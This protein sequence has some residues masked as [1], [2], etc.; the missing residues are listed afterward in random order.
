MV[1]SYGTGVV[2]LRQLSG[3]IAP[4]LRNGLWR[5]GSRGWCDDVV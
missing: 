3:Q 4:A 1:F 2:L 5:V